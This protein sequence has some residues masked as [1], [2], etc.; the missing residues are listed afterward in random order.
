M[1]SEPNWFLLTTAVKNHWQMD[2]RTT[3]D[4]NFVYATYFPFFSATIQGLLIKQ[5]D[6]VPSTLR[7]TH[8]A[9]VYCRLLV[10]FFVSCLCSLSLSVFL[11][12][13]SASSSP[14]SPLLF[15][16]LVMDRYVLFL[17]SSQSLFASS[18]HS[19]FSFFN[20]LG[21]RTSNVNVDSTTDF[22]LAYLCFCLLLE[23]IVCVKLSSW[24]RQLPYRLHPDM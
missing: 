1:V 13:V 2:W 22:P 9:L 23:T 8:V 20:A 14:S 21:N 17:A 7:C 11:S 18:L 19:S 10:F 5:I 24:K 15:N 4:L 3:D 16:Y 6:I 12:F